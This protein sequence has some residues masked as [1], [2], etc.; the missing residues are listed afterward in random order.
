MEKANADLL[1]KLSKVEEDI[2]LMLEEAADSLKLLSDM[3]VDPS[4]DEIKQN[5]VLSTK[6]FTDKVNSICDNLISFTSHAQ[7]H[8]VFNQSNYGKY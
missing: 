5:I 2:A 1:I 4:D 3:A 7:A 8:R 6:T